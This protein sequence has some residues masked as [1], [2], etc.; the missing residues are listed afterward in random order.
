MYL[1]GVWFGSAWYSI[2]VI[3]GEEGDVEYRMNLHGPGKCQ[4]KSILANSSS[5]GERPK[6][7]G[8]EFP[9]RS[10]CGNIGS[11]QPDLVAFLK[12]WVALTSS[13]VEILVLVSGEGEGAAK[14]IVYVEEGFSDGV[15]E[16]G[17]LVYG[18]HAS[19]IWVITVI[20]EE[21]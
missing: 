14:L 13:I 8:G 3:S 19:K 12:T 16:G 7:L 21:W 17:R 4:S 18:G 2:A 9:G 6:S 5:D 15:G 1:W 20:G 10:I 11:F